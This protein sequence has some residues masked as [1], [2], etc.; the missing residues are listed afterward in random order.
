[1][2]T[3]IPNSPMGALERFLRKA[4]QPEDAALLRGILF[5]ADCNVLDPNQ[6][7]CERLEHLPW[8]DAVCEHYGFTRKQWR[9]VVPVVFGPR[10]EEEYPTRLLAFLTAYDALAGTNHLHDKGNLC[11]EDQ[12]L[13]QQDTDDDDEES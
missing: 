12:V 3:F 2:S 10:A 7:C 13:W 4:S 8:T 6:L 1:M 5:D 9:K 11:L